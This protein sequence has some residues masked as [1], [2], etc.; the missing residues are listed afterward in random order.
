MAIA[1]FVVDSAPMNRAFSAAI[2]D[3]ISPDLA[4][5]M[6]AIVPSQLIRLFPSTLNIALGPNTARRRLLWAAP[7]S[8]ASSSADHGV[9]HLRAPRGG[10]PATASRMAN[11]GLS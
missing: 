2:V 11:S 3:R 9:I 8:L 10:S 7:A 5:I 6:L 4:S 1:P